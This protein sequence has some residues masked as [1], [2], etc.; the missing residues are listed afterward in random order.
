MVRGKSFWSGLLLGT[1]VLLRPEAL[2]FLCAALLASPLLPRHASRTVSRATLLGGAALA[3]APLEVFSL[4]HFD[5]LV[6]PHVRVNTVDLGRDWL[7]S[8]GT[9]LWSWFAARSD[10]S[11]WR[12]APVTA[13]AVVSLAIRTARPGRAFLWVVALVNIGL[14]VTTAPNDGGGQW[15]PRYL[16]F[17]YVPL[18]V[19]AADAVDAAMSRK[20][21]GVAVALVALLAWSLWL[22]RTSYRQL[23]G[24]KA[25]YGRIVEFVGAKAAPG[26]HIVTNVWW[27]DQIAAASTEGRELFYVPDDAAGRAVVRRLSDSEIP[28]VTIFRVGSDTPPGAEWARGT[29]YVEEARDRIS[30]RDLVALRLSRRCPPFPGARGNPDSPGRN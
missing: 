25:T 7:F 24:T 10:A 20:H 26:V 17:S 16:L 5:A 9:L 14:V 4:V 30:T 8:R 21:V 29:C 22:Q 3:L 11:F 15:G 18:V 12:V 27:L 2:W 1:A 6:P 19:L 13:C 28:A 23:R